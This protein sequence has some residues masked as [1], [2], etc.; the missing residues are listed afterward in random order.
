MTG[1]LLVDGRV[2]DSMVYWPFVDV[3]DVAAAHAPGAANQRILVAS[4]MFSQQLI[5]NMLYTSDRVPAEIK[6]NIPVGK[7]AKNIP[8]PY[9]YSFDASKSEKLLGIKCR[10]LQ[11]R[12][13]D[14]VLNLVEA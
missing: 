14:M 1:E 9:V 11:E 5:C 3:R 4:E 10:R 12:I 6:A 8:G 2:P 13:V 7:P